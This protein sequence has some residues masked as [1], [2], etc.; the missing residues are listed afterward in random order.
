[1][2]MYPFAMTIL[3][4]KLFSFAI[5][6]ILL[7]LIVSVILFG[8]NLQEQVP[9]LRKSLVNIAF[10]WISYLA[11]LVIGIIP[12]SIELDVDYSFYLGEG[13]KQTYKRPKGRV[14]T[15]VANHTSG[16]DGLVLL[17]ALCGDLS[18]IAM[19]TLQ[20]LPIAGALLKSLQTIFAPR[21]GSSFEKQK[22]VE[23]MVSR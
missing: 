1:M 8:Q 6:I 3:P 15:Y 14:S 19:D 13:Y 12:T 16:V 9:K 2:K 17:N 11:C 21:G 18:L 20:N 22:M 5:L 7:Y 4:F 10:T 23:V